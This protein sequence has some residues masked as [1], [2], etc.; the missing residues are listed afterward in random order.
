VTV[1]KTTTV[2]HSDQF[3]SPLRP[4]A[5]LTVNARI[6][7]Q[8]SLCSADGDQLACD[9]NSDSV[10]KSCSTFLPAPS[11]PTRHPCPSPMGG[12]A[13][14]DEKDTDRRVHEAIPHLPLGTAPAPIRYEHV[15]T[16]VPVFPSLGRRC[17][18]SLRLI[19]L[20]VSASYL[21]D[22]A[23]ESVPEWVRV[24]ALHRPSSWLHPN[25]SESEPMQT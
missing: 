2:V 1:S 12:V 13:D 6:R 5:L 15:D 19:C 21:E 24:A 11:R 18:A 14:F 23:T 20:R 4:K 3:R 10:Q 25:P 8:T 9:T 22:I 16:S 17:S 7:P